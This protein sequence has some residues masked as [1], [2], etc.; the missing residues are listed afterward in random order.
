MARARR[1]LQRLPA[2]RWSL[3]TRLVA[4]CVVLSAIALAVAGFAGVALLRSYLLRQVDQQLHVGIGA[5]QRFPADAPPLPRPIEEPRRQLPTPLVFV[6]L[7]AAGKT[8]QR[9]GGSLPSGTA[10]PD[11][12]GLTLHE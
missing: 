8:Q 9:F 6:R 7:D 10:V 12:S 11:L 3:R 5:G 1:L 2:H 4:A